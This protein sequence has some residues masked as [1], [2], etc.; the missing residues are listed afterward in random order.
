MMNNLFLEEGSEIIL[1]NVTLEK[2]NFVVIQPHETAF[3]DLT[4]PKAM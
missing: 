4:N 3:I 2:G 1:R